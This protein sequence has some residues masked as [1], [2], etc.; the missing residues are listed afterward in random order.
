[1]TSKTELSRLGIVPGQNMNLELAA[2][3]GQRHQARMIGVMPQRSVLVGTPMIGENRPLLVR[4][5]QEVIVRFF[6]NKTACAFRSVVRH[7]CTT[8]FHYLHLSYPPQVEVGE[9]R[10][11]SRVMANI[12]ISAIN[13]SQHGVEAI[14]GGVV[15]L[16]TVGAKIETMQPIGDV[17]DVILLTAK[18]EIGRLKQIVSWEVEIKIVLDKLDL[19]N[20]QAAYGVEFRYLKDPD[21]LALHAYVNAQIAKGAQL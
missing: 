5:E 9:I 14:P 21:Y 13:K 4:K 16:S 17:G 11:A 1:M 7:I 2:S 20:S 18:I 8:P 10:K 19:K 3:E 12:N 6:S 15:D